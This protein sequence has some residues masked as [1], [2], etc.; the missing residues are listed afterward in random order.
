MQTS[1]Q[2]LAKF[3]VVQPEKTLTHWSLGDMEV[4]QKSIP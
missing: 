3:L 4:R 2:Q 1:N